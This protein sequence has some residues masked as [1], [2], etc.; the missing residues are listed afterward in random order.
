M[1]VEIAYP[2]WRGKRSR[3]T[4]RMR[5]P[6]WYVS[7]KRPME[8]KISMQFY[9]SFFQYSLSG[10]AFTMGKLVLNHWDL[11]TPCGLKAP[12]HNLKQCWLIISKLCV[13]FQLWGQEKNDHHFADDTFK[14]IFLNENIRISLKVSLRSVPKGP[15]NNIPAL[16]QI[17]AW[18]FVGAKLGLNELIEQFYW[19]CWK[20]FSFI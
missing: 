8:K 3:H 13:I 11:V 6:Q 10:Y 17:M 1:H 2:R 12:S 4:R 18:R 16:V 19:N 14:R 5:N 15:I 20:Y 7:G 9:F